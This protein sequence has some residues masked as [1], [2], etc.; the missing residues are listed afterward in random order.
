MDDFFASSSFA[1]IV[2]I[3]LLRLIEASFSSAE[4]DSKISRFFSLVSIVSSFLDDAMSS[5]ITLF[6]SSSSSSSST[7]RPRRHRPWW[8]SSFAQNK[9]LKTLK[10]KTKNP[11]LHVLLIFFVPTNGLFFRFD[12]DNKGDA[13]KTFAKRGCT[14]PSK[15]SAFV[16]R[17][18]K[19]LSTLLSLSLFSQSVGHRRL[20]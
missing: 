3:I 20:F 2:V 5:A 10:T 6:F 18:V 17:L 14:F 7:P 9:T 19:A 16:P 4:T 1:S 15:S 13:T 8:H 12:D 11:L